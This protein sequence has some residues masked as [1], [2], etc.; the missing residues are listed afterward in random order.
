MLEFTGGLYKENGWDG[1]Y[2]VSYVN[3]ARQP[4]PPNS[5]HIYANHVV[6]RNNGYSGF[7]VTGEITNGGS[8]I[9]DGHTGNYGA[10]TNL[11]LSMHGGYYGHNGE[12]GIYLLGLDP[13]QDNA[14]GALQASLTDV[15]AEFNDGNGVNASG[16]VP[17][18]NGNGT[19]STN[20][21]DDHHGGA[22][23]QFVR[24]FYG[25]NGEDGINLNLTIV[26]LFNGDG[27]ALTNDNGIDEPSSLAMFD[28]VVANHND[29]RGVALNVFIADING[30][31]GDPGDL[32][33]ALP[34]NNH[35][36]EPAPVE[37][38]GGVFNH[39]GRAGI[40][41][42]LDADFEEETTD[43]PHLQDVAIRLTDVVASSNGANGLAIRN[44]EP[45]VLEPNVEIIRGSY[46]HNGNDGIQLRSLGTV[47]LYRAHVIGN[48]DNGIDYSFPTELLNE[49]SIVVANRNGDFRY[50]GP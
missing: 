43:P 42:T 48:H 34:N 24:G 32:L 11:Y 13:Q 19:E 12:D 18:E 14:I 27:G 31:P 45:A 29:G 4:A 33:T 9:E 16:L 8:D 44:F 38:R 6:A 49:Q 28:H 20:P 3:D 26:P 30:D 23:I 1:I 7:N 40:V 2:V 25:F 47:L 15:V 37:F 41:M 21:G 10:G 22:R 36:S 39:N 5:L 35:V 50:T 17:F 46:N